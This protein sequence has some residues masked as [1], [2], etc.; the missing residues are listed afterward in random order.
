M[1]HVGRLWAS[2]LS[3][4]TANC[5]RNRPRTLFE[6]GCLG[7][8]Y[9]HQPSCPCPIRFSHLSARPHQMSLEN[10]LSALAALSIEP[11]G[12][13]VHAVACDPASWK[14]ALDGAP[15]STKAAVPSSYKLTKTLIFK[16][17]TAKTATPVPVV[18]IASDETDT[19]NSTALGKRI[20]QKE[21]RLAGDDLIREFFALDKDSRASNSS[22]RQILI[23]SICCSLSPFH[24]CGC[25]LQSDHRT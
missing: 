16:P 22:V 13:L 24:Q 18:V 10:T 12:S 11:K 15:A 23:D 4:T 1:S 21:L 9:A 3:F 14:A 19:K 7:L 25:I 6:S 5:A 8:K 20:N 2:T 17:K